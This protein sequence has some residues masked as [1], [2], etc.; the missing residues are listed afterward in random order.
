MGDPQFVL[1]SGSSVR[2]TLLGN[3]GY[4]FDIEPAQIDEAAIQADLFRT[5]ARADDVALSLA[6]EK[7]SEVSR[8]RTEETVIGADQLLEFNGALLTKVDDSDGA[9][10]RLSALNGKTHDLISAHAIFRNGKRLT[11]GVKRVRVTMR[12]SSEEVLRV[13]VETN[14]PRLISSVTCYEL[15][16][17]G[18]R[19]IE[20]IDGDFF[21]ALGL[22]LLEVASFL[23][24]FDE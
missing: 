19:L 15:E 17:A 7:A 16:S 13:Y 11:A 18:I 5:S 2:R 22:N 12:Q 6:I 14:G 9:L 3:A 10:E 4:K 1:A 8:R 24:G 23:D 20:R 21:S